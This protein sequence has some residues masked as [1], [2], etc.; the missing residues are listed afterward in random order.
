MKQFASGQQPP[1]STRKRQSRHRR[2]K[3]NPSWGLGCLLLLAVAAVMAVTMR[4]A[5]VES[6]GESLQSVVW[7]AAGQQTTV[8]SSV[9]DVS[10]EEET[11]QNAEGQTTTDEDIPI[12]LL[13]LRE[14]NPETADFVAQYSALH[15]LHPTIDLTE[16]AASATVPL[17][18]QWDTR[19]GY[20]T[21]G[22]GMIAYTGCGPTCLSMVVL[23]LTGD[24]EAT[25]LA[26]ARYA[27]EAGYYVYGQGTAWSLMSDGCQHFGISSRDLD[28]NEQK[29]K[30]ALDEGHPIICS[31]RPGD[32]TDT[33]HYIVLTGYDEDGF[34]VNDPNSIVRSSQSWTY[35]RLEGQIRNLWVFSVL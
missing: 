15:D 34:R 30:A 21:Y 13:E 33:G 5:V 4:P 19:W 3:K 24:T 6:A 8:D 9:S 18:L 31:V 22:S 10:Q 7:A 28:L 17:L 26:I 2:R 25:P 14:K 20:E 12:E 23:Y 11:T 29:M 1:V 35:E 32:F 27:E 16:E